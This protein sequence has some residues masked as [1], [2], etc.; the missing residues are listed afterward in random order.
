MNLLDGSRGP[1][2]E[3]WTDWEVHPTSHF[4]ASSNG[5]FN[6]TGQRNSYRIGPWATSMLL[7]TATLLAAPGCLSSG[8][9]GKSGGLADLMPGH[10]EAALRKRVDADSFPDAAHALHA[11]PGAAGDGTPS[12]N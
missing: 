9:G 6:V 7:V 11:P 1:L 8:P 10:Q 4:F 5:A 12:G 2:G 3:K